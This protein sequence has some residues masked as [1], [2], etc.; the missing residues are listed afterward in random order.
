MTIGQKIVKNQIL[1]L[2]EAHLVLDDLTTL[3][4]EGCW[5]SPEWAT[6]L[7]KYYMV[8]KASACVREAAWRAI[9]KAFLEAYDGERL[10][11]AEHETEDM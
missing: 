7:S 9:A 2:G 11:N 5:K 10:A 3:E 4:K 8:S 1:G 6:E